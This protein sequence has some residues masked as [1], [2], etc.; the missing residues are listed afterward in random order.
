MGLTLERRTSRGPTRS[1]NGE[2]DDADG[3][4]RPGVASVVGAPEI[5]R[6][7]SVVL[8]RS[9]GDDMEGDELERV[10]ESVRDAERF[11]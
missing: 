2:R 10:F 1:R 8:V 7:V 6:V 3:S 5:W 9:H 11:F 4:R